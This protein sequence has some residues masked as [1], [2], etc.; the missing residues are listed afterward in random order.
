MFAVPTIAAP[1]STTAAAAA[2]PAQPEKVA[3]DDEQAAIDASLQS[4][5]GIVPTLQ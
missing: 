2:A 4:V 5:A 1:G 3:V